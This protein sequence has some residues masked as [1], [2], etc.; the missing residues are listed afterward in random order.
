MPSTSIVQTPHDVEAFLKEQEAQGFSVFRP[1]YSGSYGVNSGTRSGYRHYG[2]R[3]G[4]P[5]MDEGKLISRPGYAWVRTSIDKSY[6]RDDSPGRSGGSGF[7]VKMKP[8]KAPPKKDPPAAP[9][10]KQKRPP[11]K[12]DPVTKKAQEVERKERTKDLSVAGYSSADAGS[13]KPLQN[14]VEA[15]APGW[16]PGKNKSFTERD[17]DYLKS[18][19]IGDREIF[20]EGVKRDL[21]FSKGMKQAWQNELAVNPDDAFSFMNLYKSGLMNSMYGDLDAR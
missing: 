7:W 12:P 16:K 9:P 10:V 13:N 3:P 19:G 20:N 11:F 2:W 8:D 4:E 17:Y 18:R 1:G 15:L 14:A 6:N 21:N 5:G